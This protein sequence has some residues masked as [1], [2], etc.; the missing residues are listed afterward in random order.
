MDSTPRGT[1]LRPRA[2]GAARYR[3]EAQLGAGGMGVI[4]RAYDQLA[5]REVA[6][7]RLTVERESQ[8]PL[9]TALF[10]REY[11]TL[12][13]LPHPNIVEVFDYGEDESGPFYAMEL[14][15][16]S[17]LTTLAPLPPQEAC[18]VMRDVASALALVHARRLLYRDV[19]PNNVRLTADGKAKLLDFG[20]VAPFGRPRELVGTA[21]F[22]APECLGDRALDQRSDL[23]ALGALLYW[24]LTGYVAIDARTLDERIA[25]GYAPP[26]PPSVYVRGISRAL[27]ELVLALLAADPA[28]R[29]LSAAYVI[30]RLTSAAELLPEADE[31]RVAESYLAHP[32]LCG[33]DATLATLGEAI[34]GA[35][36]GAGRA[37][38]IE[39]E[40]GLGRTALLDAAA[41]RAQLAGA[42]VLRA[43]GDGNAAP[44]HVARILVEAISVLYPDLETEA[45][46]PSSIMIERPD[47]SGAVKDAVANAGRHAK[48]IASIQD[49]LR[50]VSLRAPV[51]LV[52]DDA[53]RADEE[54]VSTLAALTR[55]LGAMRLSMVV[56]GL[57]GQTGHGGVAYTALANAATR[58]PLAPLEARDVRELVLTLFG[59]APNTVPLSQWLHTESGG[60][61][62]TLLDLTRLLLSRGLVRYTLGT[63]TLPYAISDD[64]DRDALRTAALARLGDLSGDVAKVA[65]ALAL[66]ER[67][68]TVAQLAAAVELPLPALL[69]A[70]EALVRRGVAI[71]GEEGV[72]FVG[73][74]LRVAL[75]ATLEE[76]VRRALHRALGRALLAH[77]SEQVDLRIEASQ[78]LLAAGDEDEALDLVVGHV[79]K[80]LFGTVAGRW[81]AYLEEALAV[82]LRRGRSKEQR[83]SLLLPIA[84]G[85][86]HGGMASHARHIDTAIAWTADVC[87]MSL[88][89]RLRPYVG[90]TLALLIGILYGAIRRLRTP[91]RDRL[92]SVSLMIGYFVGLVCDAVAMATLLNDGPAARRYV[93]QLAPL[94]A[95]PRTTPGGA[96]HLFCVATADL[97][98][99]RPDRAT[100]RYAQVLAVLHKPLKGFEH[101]QPILYLGALNGRALSEAALGNLEALAL[102]DALGTDAFFA[103]HAAVVRTCYHANRGEREQA[104]LHQER[105]ALLA[106]RGGTSFSAAMTLDQTNAYTAALCEDAIGLVQAIAGL[107]R[108][109]D[110]A[111][112]LRTYAAICEAWLE[113]VRGRSAHALELMEAVIDTPEAS[114]LITRVI[115]RA[116]HAR[117]LSAAGNH[118]RAI[119]VCTAQMAQPEQQ[120]EQTPAM[121]YLQ[122]QLAIAEA[123]VGRFAQASERAEAQLALALPLGNPFE[124]GACHRDRARIALVAGDGP[125]FEA[126]LAAMEA[127]FR[128]TKN[129]CLM[130]QVDALVAAAVQAG[131]RTEVR[132]IRSIPP[133]RPRDDLSDEQ[134]FVASLPPAGREKKAT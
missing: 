4:Y 91:A 123:G 73:E 70:V 127:A 131:V 35:L 59:G 74:S 32:P 128:A 20:A 107:E 39:G 100:H 118:A 47:A 37:V 53:Q 24:T 81:S 14:L 120:G 117:L 87:G 93:N 71:S 17:D 1:A 50:E 72:G 113:H 121:R 110:A 28:E 129:P 60:N 43:R 56:G 40:P 65:G 109:G 102:A 94:D 49:A 33:R 122:R 116:L 69:R 88:G 86:F 106:L 85:G 44:F 2:R 31:R 134:T 13:R 16:G 130:A 58:V 26:P 15:G 18:R 75:A 92:G 105:A 51:V 125:T 112:M 46:T 103:T 66:H 78:H 133:R 64:L 52:V 79:H 9:R 57:A 97:A 8:R 22:L 68:L 99:G 48:V 23:F 111:P 63:F 101:A 12:R 80:S 7:K 77:P 38:L 45:R 98:E 54:S 41:A 83:L 90:G 126:H 132:V 115:N 19:S 30:D 34:D 42:V 84:A 3:L 61:P 124:I 76:G 96:M 25:R 67:T 5:Q 95:L 114:G 36:A 119:E 55:S 11:D 104:D 6:Y 62:A 108:A 21:A 82:A 29:P 10:Q 27:D 89:K